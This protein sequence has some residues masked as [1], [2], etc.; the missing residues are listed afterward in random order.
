MCTRTGYRH[1]I[2]V[3]KVSTRSS[4]MYGDDTMSI[5]RFFWR[6]QTS[7]RLAAIPWLFCFAEFNSA[8]TFSTVVLVYDV[9]RRLV[10]PPT[11]FTLKVP[12]L[13]RNVSATNVDLDEINP[14]THLPSPRSPR[15]HCLRHLVLFVVDRYANDSQT[16]LLSLVVT[17]IEQVLMKRRALRST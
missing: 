5:S 11:S 12:T 3:A 17:A 9:V 8:A 4:D 13:R 15:T 1:C 6:F 16:V 10:V 7:Q 2:H 14:V